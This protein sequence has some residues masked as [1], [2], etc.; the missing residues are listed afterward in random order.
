MHQ[1]LYSSGISLLLICAGAILAF[2]VTT[3]TSVFNLHTAGWVIMFVGLLG[4]FMPRRSYGWL[5]RRVIRRTRT[6]PVDQD[7]EQPP[8]MLTRGEA[9]VVEDMYEE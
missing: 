8:G 6:I 2:A 7:A 4:L 3:N 1:P 9:K 5:G